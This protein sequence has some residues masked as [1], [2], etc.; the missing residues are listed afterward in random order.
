[1][2]GIVRYP[3]LLDDHVAFVSEDALW[4]V[5]STGGRAER[6]AVLQGHPAHLHADPAGGRI[7]FTSTEEGARDV[8]LWE[9][10]R[11]VSVAMKTRPTTVIA[12]IILYISAL[13]LPARN[14]TII[15]VN[16]GSV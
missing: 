15:F 3:T 12:S 16:P 11:P 2:L 1:M 4:W 14:R 7:A 8:Y 13:L 9:D 6:I 10:G 5:D